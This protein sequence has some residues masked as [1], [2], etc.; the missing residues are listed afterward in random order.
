MGMLRARLESR[1]NSTSK[2]NDSYNE[3]VKMLE[4]VKN[5]EQILNG[6]SDKVGAIRFLEEFVMIMD[7]AAAS[8]GEIK[9][10][11]EY[12]IPLAEKA[13]QEIHDTISK[14]SGESYQEADKSALDMQQS[15]IDEAVRVAAASTPNGPDLTMLKKIQEPPIQKSSE[16]SKKE[17]EA[18]LA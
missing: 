16:L 11:I 5:G 17:L 1:V 8:V 15:I 14:M 12:M 4:L 18:E 6:L 10:D 9:G 13:L 3:L 2:G 7:S